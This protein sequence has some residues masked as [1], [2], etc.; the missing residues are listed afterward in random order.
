MDHRS[1]RARG[2]ALLVAA[3]SCFGVSPSSAQS[4]GKRGVMRIERIDASKAPGVRVYLTDLN[5]EMKPV[6]DR[7]PASYR[8]TIDGEI[9]SGA[10]KVQS[11]YEL[12]E[13][14]ALT[15]VIQVSP[16]MKDV[17]M[18]TVEACKLI[19]KALPEN[20]KIG[21]IAYTDVVVEET[22]PTSARQIRR[23]IDN[24]R[25]RESVR[26]HL[27]DAIREALRGLIEPKLP[28]RKV[29][30]VFSDGL[31]SDLK[32]ETFRD[33]ARKAKERGVSIHSIGY[34]PL[35]P[36]RLVPT[37]KELS[38][39]ASGTF[40]A[41]QSASE[42]SLAFDALQLELLKQRVLSYEAKK[43][44][45]GK[46]H[47]F[48]VEL[49]D[50]MASS[51]LSAL[52]PKFEEPTVQQTKE[53]ES[54]GSPILLVLL[55]GGGVILVTLLTL[56]IFRFRSKPNISHLAS[57]KFSDSDLDDDDDDEFEDDDEVEDDEEVEAKDDTPGAG[58]GSRGADPYSRYKKRKGGRSRR[59]ALDDPGEDG[60]E[61]GGDGAGGGRL[62][63]LPITDH[64]SIDNLFRSSS[65]RGSADNSSVSALPV[66]GG[67]AQPVSPPRAAP[68]MPAA[69]VAPHLPQPNVAPPMAPQF[70]GAAPVA[71]PA[72]PP[73]PAG[74][75]QGFRLPSPEE[76]LQ[77]KVSPNAGPDLSSNLLGVG[78]PISLPSPEDF[79]RGT[80]SSFTDPRVAAPAASDPA[81]AALPAEPIVGPSPSAN[82]FAPV[83]PTFSSGSGSSSVAGTGI[84]IAPNIPAAPV[85]MHA[86]PQEG[87]QPGR[88]LNRKTQ[89]MAVEEI[90][91]L[92]FN[93]WIVPLF[94]AD[95][96]TQVIRPDFRVGAAPDSDFQVSGDRV[97][98]LEGMFQLTDKGYRLLTWDDDANELLVE[99]TDGLEFNI[100]Y[101]PFVYS[102]AKRFV[103]R[104]VG[105][106]RLEVLDGIDQGRSVALDDGLA[107]VIGSHASCDLVVRAGNVGSR[108]VIAL[109]KDRRCLIADLGA[110]GGITKGGEPLG[111]G[112]LS[113]GDEIKIGD[114]R[115]LFTLE[116]WDNN[117][118][119][120]TENG[121]SQ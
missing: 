40:R 67:A 78:G 99:M 112:Q 14:I 27:P 1:N 98:E 12:S 108:H 34:A 9:L 105:A 33:L 43:F 75:N 91:S 85:V 55:I 73:P 107:Y 44:F 56:L 80:A 36:A 109:R 70:G 82:D 84:P 93:A 77:Q 114:I 81:A 102:I 26:V 28:A 115:L 61:D 39:R 111:H 110:P 120:D 48:Q 31:T 113:P 86:V 63:R 13:P 97:R 4:G 68:A 51:L 42:V 3:L 101:F 66:S 89:V 21:L 25:I 15:F 62:G 87:V 29:M 2:L 17:L 24:L 65:S 103:D 60:A 35:E 83:A 119:A 94:E 69:G 96:T 121:E 32:T 54:V 104:E 22:K 19:V 23:K 90:Q 118:S 18:E 52:L 57:G 74:G 71:P 46:S 58:G 59:G 30:V 106:V 117:F 76:F 16:A 37:L 72:V 64:R 92:D 50:G 8:L 88:L 79:L 100:G 7:L 116:D 10:T 49:P 47:E 20:S 41:T 95:F 5:S 53:V 6:V 38:N 11:Y 45:D